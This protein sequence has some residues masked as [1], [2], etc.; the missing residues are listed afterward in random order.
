MPK[1]SYLKPS[2]AHK[3]FFLTRIENH[4]ATARTGSRA[5]RREDPLRHASRRYSGSVC[6]AFLSDPWRRASEFPPHGVDDS[7]A[8][9]VSGAAA[10]ARDAGGRRGQCCPQPK[11]AARK[12]RWN[13]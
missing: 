6:N 11:A 7:A 5:L 10:Q 1:V 3:R 12:R 2:S 4:E 9:R 8:V 13:G